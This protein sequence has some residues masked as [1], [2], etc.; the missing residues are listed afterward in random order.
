MGTLR[1]AGGGNLSRHLPA[2]LALLVGVCLAGLAFLEAQNLLG[3][4]AAAPATVYPWCFC[5]DV[6]FRRPGAWNGWWR[7]ALRRS[8]R[9]T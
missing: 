4:R 7:S 1:G 9:P 5:I 3:Q 2:A 6:A 8:R